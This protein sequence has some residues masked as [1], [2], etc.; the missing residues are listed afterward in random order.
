MSAFAAPII[1][2]STDS[3]LLHR[4]ELK[5]PHFSEDWLQGHLFRHPESLPLRELE[6]N[7]GPLV[8][9]C[10]EMKSL[11][12]Y[13]DLVYVTPTGQIVLGETKLWRNAEARREVVAQ[14][15]DYAQSLTSWRYEDL[16][17][18]VARCRVPIGCSPGQVWETGVT[19]LQTSRQDCPG[20]QP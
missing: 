12:G 1:V 17:R 20:E 3:H 7:L 6:P 10:K 9:L 16:A 18:E 11:V 14:I 8:P 15:L 5:G 2:N 4:L 13:M 19:T